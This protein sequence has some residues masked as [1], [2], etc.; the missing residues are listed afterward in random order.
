MTNPTTDIAIVNNTG[1]SE[2]Y[3]YINGLDINS[4]NVPLFIQ[5][6]GKT[7]YR[8]A[9]P[10]ATQ[11]ALTEDIA[12]PLGA[13]GSTTTVTI[14]QIAGGRIWFSTGGT[15]LTFLVNP[16]PA[17]VEPSVTNTADPNYAIDW[18]FAEFTYNTE[19]LFVNISYVDF[20][21][22]IPV[23]LQL[24]NTAGATQTV[25]GMP[26]NGLATVVDKLTQQ[27]ASDGA[28]WDKLIVKSSD[29][30]VLRALSPNSARVGDNTLFNGYFDSYID[31]VWS[32]YTSADLTIDTQASWG[33]VT[34]RVQNDAITFA[35][36]GSFARPSAGDIFS[37]ST[38][39]FGNYPAATSD[40][41]G[42]LGAR[43]AAAFNRSTLMANDQQPDG[44]QVANYYKASP[45]NHYARIVHET[46]ID[47]RGYAFPYDD[48]VPS[49]ATQPD[50]AGTVFDGSPKLLTVTLGGPASD[51][52]AKGGDGKEKTPDTG[53]GGGGD[54]GSGSG[55][56]EKLKTC[57]KTAK[58]TKAKTRSK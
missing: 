34:G 25:Q 16:G 54:G 5:A 8:P 47:N 14:P 55:V 28:G 42:A 17:I 3:A 10:S 6:D 30:R 32:K 53:N 24:V 39:P 4:N 11:T 26:A 23:A 40:E 49:G 57:A 27:N 1:S 56:W 7:V 46:N 52:P 37:C 51:G 31:Q 35:N 33:K 58:A 20:V 2:A 18:G 13:A 15:K 44:E 22:P 36:V 41:M 38:G 43:I 50:P 45:T 12:I 48:V 29:G 21:P 19:Q 9:N